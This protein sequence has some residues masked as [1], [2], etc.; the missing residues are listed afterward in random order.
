MT[1]T[2]ELIQVDSVTIAENGEKVLERERQL[3]EL[4]EERIQ[5][6]AL[7]QEI[8]ETIERQGKTITTLNNSLV[9]RDEE[10]DRLN[11]AALENS[12]TFENIKLKLETSN[13]HLFKMLDEHEGAF[14]SDEKFA[15]A[16]ICRDYLD[17]A[18]YCEK[19]FGRVGNKVPQA[20]EWYDSLMPW[21]Q[22]DKL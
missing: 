15:S 4:Q 19:Y 14:D 2:T 8:R 17:A 11:Q 5:T 6:L 20:Q 16:E 18:M 10:I 7:I 9:K 21:E 13:M 1:A 22:T 12:I 3:K